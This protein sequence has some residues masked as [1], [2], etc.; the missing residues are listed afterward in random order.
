MQWK[1]FFKPTKWKIILLIAL[2]IITFFLG[3][4]ERSNCFIDS[5]GEEICRKCGLEGVFNP[6]L[7]PISFLL[8][9]VY[10]GLIESGNL[11]VCGASLTFYSLLPFDLV[12]LYIISCT[13]IYI[14]K[15]F[16]K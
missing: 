7:R 16:K 5:N 15:K 6:I 13:I 8:S 11:Q 14:H 4:F 1:E 12:Y 10:M 3:F 9:N 2:L